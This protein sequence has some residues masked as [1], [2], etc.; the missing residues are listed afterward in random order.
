MSGS[1]PIIREAEPGDAGGMARVQVASWQAA[2]PGLIDQGFLDSLDVEGRTQSWARILHQ[3][4]GRVLLAESRGVVIG[5]CAV[6]PA[7]DEDWGEV[8]ALYLDPTRWG[9]GV[10]RD[11]LA[12]GERGLAGAGYR[13]ALLWVLE[14]NTRARAF[15]A[16]QGWGLGKPI[17]IEAIGGVDVTEVRY[18]KVLAAV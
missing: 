16:R 3:P 1:R 4:R 14:G 5:F 11:M 10:G 13:Q 15:Y 8:F 7:L 17:R 18:E 6:G 9:K 12:A 2:Y